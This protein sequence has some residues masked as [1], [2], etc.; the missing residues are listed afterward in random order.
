MRGISFL[1][2]L[3][4]VTVG[5]DIAHAD[6]RSF[7]QTYEYSTTPQGTTDLELWHTQA[8]RTWDSDTPQ[9]F[10]QIVEIEHGLTDKWDMAF[11]TVFEQVNGDAMTAEPYHFSEAKLET[12]YRLADRGEPV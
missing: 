11:Y 1:C 10:E 2:G 12:R 8:R 6:V 3:L 5:A 4:G 7:T 9:R